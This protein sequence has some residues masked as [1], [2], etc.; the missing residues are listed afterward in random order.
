M[1]S[2]DSANKRTF[3]VEEANRALPLVKAIV[4]D[5]AQLSCDVVDRRER[6]TE[7]TAGRDLQEGDPYGDE[8]AQMEVELE[9]DAAVLQGYIR[10]LNELGVEPR[11]GP[12][13]L[14][15][16]PALIDGRA[17]YLCWQLGEPEVLYWHRPEDG[18]AG[19][20]P[21]T[22]DSASAGCHGASAGC[23][24]TDA[25]LDSAT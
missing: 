9:K 15:D 6:L 25:S 24:G 20:Q 13:G 10:E 5:L 21:L 19:R 14:V 1:R 11:S 4:R 17:A 8:L 16:F 22:V 2:K 23:H 12:E 7:L 18:F 3:T